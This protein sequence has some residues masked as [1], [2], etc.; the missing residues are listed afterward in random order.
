MLFLRIILALGSTFIVI[1]TFTMIVLHACIYLYTHKKDLDKKQQKYVV[2]AGIVVA[3]ILVPFYY[4][5][6]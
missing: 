6:Y 2:Y 5:P 1:S 4:Q 3:S